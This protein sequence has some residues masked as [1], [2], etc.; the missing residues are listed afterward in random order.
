MVLHNCTKFYAYRMIFGRVRQGGSRICKNTPV[1]VG[2]T[3]GIVGYFSNFTSLSRHFCHVGVIF[4]N[5]MAFYNQNLKTLNSNRMKMA[6]TYFKHLL[7]VKNTNFESFF[8]FDVIMTSFD[9]IF[10]ILTSF[11][12]I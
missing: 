2:L 7:G 3:I 9:V 12:K 4:Y 10:A 5:F 8:K 6:N 11:L 1:Q